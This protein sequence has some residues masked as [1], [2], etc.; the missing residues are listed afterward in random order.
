MLWDGI[1]NGSIGNSLPSVCDLVVEG[2]FFFWKIHCC[3]RKKKAHDWNEACGLRDFTKVTNQIILES[4]FTP[5]LATFEK[6]MLLK[7][8]TIFQVESFELFFSTSLRKVFLCE[9]HLCSSQQNKKPTYPPDSCFPF[10]IVETWRDTKDPIFGLRYYRDN[11]TAGT[12]TIL[13]DIS[14]KSSTELN[15]NYV[16]YLAHLIDLALP[17]S[18]RVASTEGRR[19]SPSVWRLR[20]ALRARYAPLLCKFVKRESTRPSVV[21]GLNPI[22]NN[23]HVFNFW[24][25]FL[26]SQ[27]L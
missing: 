13:P 12:T 14:T 26:I 27:F 22:K 10:E 19:Y 9:K 5:S 4:V 8:T 6:K 2:H 23:H 21:L 3:S 18:S 1:R 20:E 17:T 15:L 25:F 24:V 7:T 16:G 11:Q